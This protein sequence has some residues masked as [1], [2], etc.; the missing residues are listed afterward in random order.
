M[1][2]DRRLDHPYAA[3][4]NID[5]SRPLIIQ[6]TQQGRAPSPPQNYSSATQRIPMNM[7]TGGIVEPGQLPPHWQRAL[8]DQILLSQQQS[9]HTFAG[10]VR[11]NPQQPGAAHP[12]SLTNDGLNAGQGA[13][14]GKTPP[15]LSQAHLPL[16][17]G[18]LH[19]GPS[20][21]RLKL[22][23]EV[24]SWQRVSPV[25]S[26][27]SPVPSNSMHLMEPQDLSNRL[28][29]F[30]PELQ[31]ISP[32]R[33][34]ELQNRT[35]PSRSSD[36]LLQRISP[37][38]IGDIAKLSI[39]IAMS[40]HSSR[41]SPVST[42]QVLARLQSSFQDSGSNTP[43]ERHSVS[44]AKIITPPR[45]PSPYQ[46]AEI[47]QPVHHVPPVS[48]AFGQNLPRL[49]GLLSNSE[50]INTNDHVSAFSQA[51]PHAHHTASPSAVRLA[52]P[53][54]IDTSTPILPP[55]RIPPVL[56]LINNG[57]HQLPLRTSE[58]VALYP[59]PPKLEAQSSSPV[60]NKDGSENKRKD[61]EVPK[62]PELVDMP[63]PFNR[64]PNT[65]SNFPSTSHRPT[66]RSHSIAMH[67]AKAG[68]IT[69]SAKSLD[70]LRQNLQKSV[71]KEIDEVIQKYVEKYFKSGMDN[72]RM[73]NGENSVTDE[74]L[75]AVCRQIME[76]AKKMYSDTRS[77]TPAGD[78]SD[79][80]SEA[81]SHVEPPVKKRQP[82]TLAGRRRKHSDSDSEA[83]QPVVSTKKKKGRFAHLH[84]GSGRLTPC[85]SVKPEQ[86]KRE[87]PKWDPERLNEDCRF[88]MGAK[89][90]KALG[91]GNTRGRLY[92]KHPN[93]FKYSGDQDDKQWLYEHG[94]M[95]AVGGKAYMLLTEDIKDLAETAEYK[96]SPGLLLHH[97]EGFTV[98]EWMLHKMR[99][100]MNGMRTDL[101]SGSKAGG[102]TS[103]TAVSRSV[104]PVDKDASSIISL[105]QADSLSDLV[106]GDDLDKTLPF[107]GSSLKSKLSEEA[108]PLNK[109]LDLL[110]DPDTDTS[111]A[112]ITQTFDYSRRRVLCVAF[113]A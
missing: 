83:S 78:I 33:L 28:S 74:H 3:G 64:R 2:A 47:P 102:G 30:H 8:S 105:D 65:L 84:G 37:L 46:S 88:V 95:P 53:V 111:L 93:V 87:G 14:R 59:E 96:D 20:F 50:L 66:Y 73:N 89:A 38:H 36:M 13:P 104:T 18:Q 32:S 94:H 48:H 100:Q 26:R 68:C 6:H 113:G 31:R 54:P 86:I 110:T 81:G 12:R 112:A 70:L 7:S 22:A 11:S 76:E 72:I 56:P 9:G 35:S 79:N 5:S 71:N 106:D 51:R 99:N 21:D 15:P 77:S 45:R 27:V 69:S 44:P 1:A 108:S 24:R 90:N 40:A 43:Q 61:V 85:K 34:A 25:Q 91:L 75:Q 39:P 97:L 10:T 55:D 109:D 49:M 41:L 16:R 17:V 23:E 57:G 4:K 42:A 19:M 62:K 92:I 82:R 67:R 80:I 63:K 101:K 98:P 107:T 52:R 60:G 29:P 58:P 103:S